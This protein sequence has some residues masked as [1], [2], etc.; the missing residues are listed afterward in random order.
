RPPGQWP[1]ALAQPP[2]PAPAGRRA[3]ALPLAKPSS[4]A[5]P[6]PPVGAAPFPW[7]VA[8]EPFPRTKH[9]PPPLRE[10][11]PSSTHCSCSYPFT[12]RA[13]AASSGGSAETRPASGHLR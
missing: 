7:A 1:P 2:H 3:A 5:G 11:A 13:A 6:P 8:A 10:A 12:T 4:A 9:P